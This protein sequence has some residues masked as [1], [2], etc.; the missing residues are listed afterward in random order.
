MDMRLSVGILRVN[1][2]L[3]ATQLEF[4]E[5]KLS[6]KESNQ[7]L[8]SEDSD[9]N[10]EGLRH[11]V[12]VD[13]GLDT[14]SIHFQDNKEKKSRKGNMKQRTGARDPIPPSSR[15]ESMTV[16]RDK[17]G[18]E[19]TVD[20]YWLYDDGGLTLLLPHILHTRKQFADCKVRV[21]SLS[22]R[23]D[24]LDNSTINLSNL[25]AKFRIDFNKVVI[26]PDITKKASAE[27][28]AKFEEVLAEYGEIDQ[29][30]IHANAA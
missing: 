10:T 25:L 11:N 12:S 30:E 29:A 1:G 2:G 4:S 26:I 19:G 27:T 3:D 14:G 15:Q 13:S 20:I 16:F 17:E 21:F 28:K 24:D 6:R 5:P 7:S 9:I 23:P 22:N 8:E 18:M